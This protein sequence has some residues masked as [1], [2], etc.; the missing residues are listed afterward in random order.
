[1]KDLAEMF[2]VTTSGTKKR[3]ENLSGV[4]CYKK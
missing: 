2:N 3:I 1:M 4:I